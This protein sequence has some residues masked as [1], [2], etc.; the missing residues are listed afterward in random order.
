MTG[1]ASD[2]WIATS[3]NRKFFAG[4]AAGLLISLVI[5][6]ILFVSLYR[7]QLESER[8]QAA[9]Q[10]NRLLQTS[11]ENAML[12]RDLEGLKTI[13]DRLGEQGDI[14]SVMITNPAGDVRFSSDPS[15]L[16]RQLQ[17]VSQLG[18]GQSTAFL[19]EGDGN[20]ILRS[21]NPVSNRD[22]CRECHGTIAQN[23]INGVLYVDYDADPIRRHAW[24]TTLLLTGSGTLIVLIN[25]AGGWWFIRRFV[26]Q[27][28]NR[29]TEASNRLSDGDLTTRVELGGRDELARL[30]DTFNQMSA[31]LGEKMQQLEEQ[32]LFLQRLID[33]IPDG[34]RIL[35]S[36]YRVLLAN[37]S[38]YKQIGHTSEAA[39]YCYTAHGRDTPCPANLITC[40]LYELR[41]PDQ[42]LRVVH[43]HQHADGSRLDV[44][45]YAVPMQVSLQGEPQQLVVESIRN[46]EQEIRF[47]HE[48]KLSELGR[49]ASGVAHEIHNPLSSVHLALHALQQ[50][51]EEQGGGGSEASGYMELVEQEI[52]K[53]IRV[54][55]MMLKLSVPPP[56]EPE[57][58]VVTTVVGEV[59][60]LLKWEAESRH[61]EIS[62]ESTGAG[63]AATAR[64]GAAAPEDP[65]RVLAT[66]SELRMVALNLAQN[67]LHAMPQGGHLQVRCER[68][69][70]EIKVHFSDN[71]TGIEPE[72]LRRVFEPFFSR[73]ADGVNG[74]GLG[75]SIS[76]SIVEKF[77]GRLEVES[78]P[79]EGSRFSVTFPDADRLE[80]G[81]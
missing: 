58:V 53:C 9:T 41:T 8:A 73:R 20:E 34:V 50:E 52:D 54:T 45:I 10:V 78:R 71:G 39:A 26:L 80:R 62:L 31:S 42:S 28:V 6:L 79:G 44:E 63:I 13:V 77:D 81:E 27:P 75:L 69:E 46:L 18:G 68:A 30:G 65:L 70:G 74:T 55:E 4:T 60:R 33:A 32:K 66:D 72:D 1:T 48:Q 64:S 67:A 49:L 59:L 11:L 37:D 35:G 36:D 16:G 22:A 12:K 61:V 5:F 57:L 38:Y 7:H 14:R 43:N 51:I 21:I 25:L 15:L 29:L 17:P 2:S 19:H 56:Q 3:L 76:K 47:S 24:T 40:P 23:P